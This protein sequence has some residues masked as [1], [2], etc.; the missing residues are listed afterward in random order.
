M[1]IDE[2]SNKPR[3][4]MRALITT[5]DG[6]GVSVLDNKPVLTA[7]EQQAQ[8]LTRLNRIILRS[9]RH[10]RSGKD[11]APRIVTFAVIA[12]ALF[13]ILVSG[14]VGSG[15]AYYQAQLPLLNGIAQHS[16]FQTTRIY[17]RNGNLLY[18]LYDHQQDKGRRTYVNYNDISQFL[19]NATIAA[20]DHT[21]WD[22]NGVDINGIVRAAFSNV[23]SQGV[24]EG[25]STVTQQLI[26]NQF[27]AG[28]PR[29][30]PVKGEEA[31]L[32]TGLTQQY[33]KWK[34]MEMY[35]NTVYYGDINYGIESAAE[36][37][38]GLQQRCTR[39]H[40]T[41]GVALLDLAQASMLAGLPQG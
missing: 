37:Y 32:A 31:L 15:Y 23:Q 8:R 7:Q 22:N 20:E 35:L 30:F 6:R 29:T 41:P 33:P 9:R 39:T 5:P 25:G 12:L 27:F 17:D 38:Y 28:Q 13:T 24:V 19:V 11:M 2:L 10:A 14:S 4:E 40:C 36:D 1:S 3:E 16:L 34:I 21:F 26:K 18:E